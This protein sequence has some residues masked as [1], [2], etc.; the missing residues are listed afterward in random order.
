MDPTSE[1]PSRKRLSAEERRGQI[2]AAARELFIAEGVENT[3]MRRIASLA[4]VTPTLIYRHF[5]DKEALLLAVCQAFF[6][7]LIE[8]SAAALGQVPDRAEPF[9][10]LR[11]LLEGYVRFG[12]ANPDVYRLVFMTKIAS[13]KRERM[14]QG[15]R[16][17]QDTPPPAE[18]E[19]FGLRAFGLLEGEIRRLIELGHLKP[20]EPTAIAEVVW[21]TGHGLVALLITHGDFKWTPFDELLALSIDVLLK[22]IAA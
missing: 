8:A 14:P 18:D 11:R 17:R 12:L 22:G 16:P 6:R 13:L 21:A 7:G 10:R 2:L 5:A 9:A 3:S 20:G 19:G 1:Q 15:H 4:G